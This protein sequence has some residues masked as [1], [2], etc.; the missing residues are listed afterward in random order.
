VCVVSSNGTDIRDNTPLTEA[1]PHIK[2]HQS[3][4]YYLRNSLKHHRTTCPRFPPPPPPPRENPSLGDSPPS[5]YP[6]PL[7]LPPTWS[8]SIPGSCY[9]HPSQ[10][11][12]RHPC[13]VSP[14]TRYGSYTISPSSDRGI[15]DADPSTGSCHTTLTPNW[16]QHHHHWGKTKEERAHSSTPSPS[17]TSLHTMRKRRT[18]H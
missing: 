10:H 3:K 11:G 12:S 7:F 15:T 5:H 14:S 2:F 4:N 6:N 18:P 16:R 9:S 13:M 1:P 8:P 17:S